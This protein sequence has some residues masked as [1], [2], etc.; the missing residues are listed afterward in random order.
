MV[1]E[2]VG[3]WQELDGLR[4]GMPT[5]HKEHVCW[6]PPPSSMV[7]INADGASMGNQGLAGAGC[8]IRIERENG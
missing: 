7:K 2:C 5:R 8:V 6:T 1:D 3:A 4:L